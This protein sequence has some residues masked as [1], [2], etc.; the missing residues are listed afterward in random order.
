MEAREKD[1]MQERIRR[2]ERRQR[3]CE[4]DIEAAQRRAE[5]WHRLKVRGWERRGGDSMTRTAVSGGV[6][7][8]LVNRQL[9]KEREHI[10]DLY[11]DLYAFEAEVERELDALDK[12]EE[13]RREE[14]RAKVRE[15]VEQ[16][17]SEL[18]AARSFVDE[19]R[20]RAENIYAQ[21]R[22]VEDALEAERSGRRVEV[23]TLEQKLANARANLEEWQV[24]KAEQEREMEEKER[25]EERAQDGEDW[26]YRLRDPK[27]MPEPE[28]D[29]E[30]DD[31]PE[32]DRDPS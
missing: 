16:I 21:L 23:K 3:E 7:A 10:G 2:L 18:Y 13:E 15:D 28:Q 4:R 25:Q 30:R 9:K 11:R 31:E 12:R 5:E 22:D 26:R 14:E 17:R 8:L 27:R 19:Y 1:R 20:T 24:K 32:I 29:R 6:N